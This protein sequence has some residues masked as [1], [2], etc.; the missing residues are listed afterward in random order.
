MH[1]EG[2]KI[3]A[4]A[5]MSESKPGALAGGK[6]QRNATTASTELTLSEKIDKLLAA[7]EHSRVSMEER[8]GNITTD[9]SLLRDDHRKLADKV[10]DWEKIIATMQHSLFHRFFLFSLI[11]TPHCIHAVLLLPC[12]FYPPVGPIPI[13]ASLRAIGGT[14]LGLPH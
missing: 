12:S 4:G 1:R 10:S 13:D 2:R 5:S 11:L 3:P 14:G 8:L 9:I 6:P 7:I